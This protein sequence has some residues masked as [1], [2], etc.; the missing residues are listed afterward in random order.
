MHPLTSKHWSLNFTFKRL[1]HSFVRK[2]LKKFKPS[3]NEESEVI[4]FQDFITEEE[5]EK[6]QEADVDKLPKS[7]QMSN[8]P[9]FDRV[10]GWDKSNPVLKELLKQIKEAKTPSNKKE[11][12]LIEGKR[13]LLDAIHAGC[14]PKHFIFSRLNL[15]EGI[16]FNVLK[17]SAKMTQIPYKNIQVWSDM[18]TSPGM[19]G[20]FDLKEVKSKVVPAD[21]ALP[22]TIVLDDIRMPDNIG[23]LARVAAS[24]GCKKLITTKVIIFIQSMNLMNNQSSKVYKFLFWLCLNP[25][26]LHIF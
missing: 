14:I 4:R 13:T 24:F 12:I 25:V 6:R 23:A 22:L 8:L 10:L 11:L 19:M 15:L 20:L 2:P 7:L 26:I 9:K 17:D 18:S 5:D 21:N 16:P 3:K 1:K